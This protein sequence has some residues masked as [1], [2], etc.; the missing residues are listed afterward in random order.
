MQSKILTV[1]LTI[2]ILFGALYIV[3]EHFKKKT[4]FET[5]DIIFQ[6]ALTSQNQ[7]IRYATKS[8]YSH[9][10]I[11]YKK[12]GTFYVYEAVQPVKITP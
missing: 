2:L 1:I 11:I 8:K 7:A 3:Y 12:D 4:L 9:C 10:G 6:T 5:G